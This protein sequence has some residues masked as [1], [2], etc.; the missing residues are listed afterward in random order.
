VFVPD[1]T[2]KYVLDVEGGAGEVRAAINLV[3]GWQ[4][5]GLGPYYMKDSSTAQNLFA[6]GVQINLGLRGAADLVNSIANLQ[7]KAAAAGGKASAADVAKVADAMA[8]AASQETFDWQYVSPEHW[9]DEFVT[10]RS[11][12]VIK[13]GR[14][15]PPAIERYAE[16]YVYEAVLEE[17]Q[18]V[19][20]PVANH[21]FA[22]EFLGTVKTTG[23]EGAAKAAGEMMKELGQSR[24]AAPE[25]EL[26]LRRLPSVEADPQLVRDVIE[27]TLAP[28]PEPPRRGCLDFLHRRPETL[29][30]RTVVAPAPGVEE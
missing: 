7:G 6:R 9:V 1:L 19:W 2:Q 28:P 22:R 26:F 11:G 27:R 25:D 10:D 30:N 20:R 23:K 5:T 29:V 3:N 13:T 18:M 24:A 16:I 17:R 12:N 21:T 4:F 15:V 8:R 14:K